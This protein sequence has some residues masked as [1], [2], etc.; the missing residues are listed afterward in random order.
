MNVAPNP[1][2]PD[3]QER[4]D[5]HNYHFFNESSRSGNQLIKLT[6]LLALVIHGLLL[7]IT[8]ALP[9]TA[10]ENTQHTSGITITLTT[11]VPG[12]KAKEAS[13]NL[14]AERETDLDE[15]KITPASISKTPSVNKESAIEAQKPAANI[16]TRTRREVAHDDAMGNRIDVSSQVTPE[17]QIPSPRRRSFQLLDQALSLAQQSAKKKE[18]ETTSDMFDRRL[19][20]ALKEVKIFN[21]P[22]VYPDK[23]IT[24]IQDASGRQFVRIANNYCFELKEAEIGLQNGT[25]W[26]FSQECPDKTN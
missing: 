12:K 5:L 21:D 18:E 6:S 10:T 9:Q 19:A 25:V 7:I 20:L 8:Y 14:Y 22:G 26:Y 11:D 24:S 2:E 16:P 3:Y 15:T 4:V 23:K 17:A 1:S 13:A